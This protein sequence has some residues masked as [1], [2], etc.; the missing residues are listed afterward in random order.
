MQCV[1][2]RNVNYSWYLK[3]SFSEM[4]F[5]S[6][7][8]NLMLS[9]AIRRKREYTRIAIKNQ[10]CL[11][12]IFYVIVDNIWEWT[13]R[14]QLKTLGFNFKLTITIIITNS[15]W[16]EFSR[17][18]GQL[19]AEY[20]FIP[21][22]G[23]KVCYNNTHIQNNKNKFLNGAWK[24]IDLKHSRNSKRPSNCNDVFIVNCILG[25]L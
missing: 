21:F 16:N 15:K 3:N 24:N 13:E 22:R 4:P 2:H 7:W 5:N 11:S 25:N 6:I 23:A 10:V 18:A 19:V 12:L 17:P 9:K 20:F 14:L 1:F 8:N